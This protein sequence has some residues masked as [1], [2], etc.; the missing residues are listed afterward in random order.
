[1]STFTN[2]IILKEG[3]VKLDFEKV[4]DTIEHSQLLPCC[5]NLTSQNNG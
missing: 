5:I 1:M 4:F 3:V 2:A